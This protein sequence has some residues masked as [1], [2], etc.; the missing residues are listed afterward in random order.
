M[1]PLW[2]RWC[3]WF[4]PVR[5]R[6]LQSTEG[7]DV[8][9]SNTWRTK[10]RNVL[11][12]IID[13]CDLSHFLPLLLI[14]FH[15]TYVNLFTPQLSSGAYGEGV[16]LQSVLPPNYKIEAQTK[17]CFSF[18]SFVFIGWY[19]C[20]CLL[21]QTIGCNDYC[22]IQMEKP[23]FVLEAS[24]ISSN[25]HNTSHKTQGKLYAW[26]SSHNSIFF[27]KGRLRSVRNRGKGY[28]NFFLPQNPSKLFPGNTNPWC[29]RWVLWELIVIILYIIV[30][31]VFKTHFLLF[32]F[33]EYYY[34]S[35]S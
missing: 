5:V 18:P 9:G 33:S 29:G 23:N 21:Q 15:E 26:K 25:L 8:K 30:P 12:F 2:A 16:S 22:I 3:V 28:Y 13:I 32:I 14:H 31:N 20:F 10:R 6:H 11:C 35:M 19:K 24:S 4:S 7:G 1:A 17:C 27:V 34:K